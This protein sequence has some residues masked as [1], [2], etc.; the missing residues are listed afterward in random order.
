MGEVAGIK[1]DFRQDAIHQ[2]G[3]GPSRQSGLLGFAHLGRRHHLH[4]FGDL[5]GVFDR[6]DPAAYVTGARHTSI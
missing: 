1:A 2:D 4:G 6:P 3:V 5:G